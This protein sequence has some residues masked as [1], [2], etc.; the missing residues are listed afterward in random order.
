MEFEQKG[1]FFGGD[2]NTWTGLNLVSQLELRRMM[3]LT[4]SKL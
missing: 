4:I 2:M 1:C 3:E